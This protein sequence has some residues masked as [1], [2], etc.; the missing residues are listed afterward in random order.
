MFHRHS[1]QPKPE[2]RSMF[3]ITFILPFCINLLSRFL[4]EHQLAATFRVEG[5][6]GNFTLGMSQCD[7]TP[8]TIVFDSIWAFCVFA[9]S[10]SLM[11]FGRLYIDGHVN[12]EG[13]WF[14]LARFVNQLPES[15]PSLLGKL[16]LRLTG[17]QGIDV[18]YGWSAEAFAR[19]LDH[20]YMQYTCA[21][22]C[23]GNDKVALEEA[24]LNKLELI[25]RWLQVKA[26]ARHLDIG[27]G[28][29]G[30]VDYMTKTHSTLS[31]GVTVV[32]EQATFAEQV[33][34]SPDASFFLQSFEM[35]TPRYQ[36]DCISVVGMLEHLPLARHPEFFHYLAARLER[37]GR[38]YL[39]CITRSP[40]RQAGDR[41]RLLNEFVFAHELSTVEEL[42]ALARAAGFEVMALEEGHLDYAFTTCEWVERMRKH[43]REIREILEDDRVYRILL[44]YLTM[45][46]LSFAEHH[47]NLHRLLLVKK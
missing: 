41:T 43:E 12:G 17:A 20:P 10:P 24:Q 22:L 19:F 38:V 35:H 5:Q 25:A 36:Y 6:G 32:P 26:G 47:S 30:L 8:F 40:S 46:S 33:V 39:Q 23:G 28:W 37:G 44:G 45:G 4:R 29:G 13:D 1:P 21:R 16:L 15:K 11:T 27:C 42:H 14:A 3:S 9:Q 31:D 34:E 7:A 18:H 2:A